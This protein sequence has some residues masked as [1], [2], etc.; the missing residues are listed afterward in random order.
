MPAIVHEEWG[1]PFLSN[2]KEGGNRSVTIS[3]KGERII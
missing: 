1:G 3:L 2:E